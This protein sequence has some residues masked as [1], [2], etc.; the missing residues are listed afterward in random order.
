MSMGSKSFPARR[1]RGQEEGGE[2]RGGGSRDHDDGKKKEPRFDRCFSGLELRIGPGPLRD[3]D[4][5]RLKLQ[6]M[7]WAKAVV[8]YAR[9]LSFGSPRSRPVNS[10]LTTAASL[11][12]AKSG[13]GGAR[14]ETPT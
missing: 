14:E 10:S 8:S 13:L 2:E 1:G 11:P 5:G 6:I 7:K 3:R 9:Q 4:A 12:A